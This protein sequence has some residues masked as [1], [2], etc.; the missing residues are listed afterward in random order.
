MMRGGTGWSISAPILA[1]IFL[2]AQMSAE[3]ADRHFKRRLSH[4][5]E[6]NLESGLNDVRFDSL[7]LRAKIFV[8][9]YETGTAFF[10]RAIY[11]VT[12]SPVEGP[13]SK[14]AWK[15]IS[16]GDKSCTADRKDEGDNVVDSVRFFNGRL[17][18]EVASI[19]FIASRNIDDPKNSTMADATTVTI[20]VYELMSPSPRPM[21]RI[22]NRYLSSRRVDSIV[23]PMRRYGRNWASLCPP[24]MR[25][26]APNTN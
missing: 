6:I 5:A 15:V 16:V 4:L 23:M 24:D 18:A 10:D 19:V 17:D 8:A 20:T 14:P 3:A 2:L 7:K 1:L 21:C 11:C 25:T 26:G 13:G 12:T 9:Q 22:S